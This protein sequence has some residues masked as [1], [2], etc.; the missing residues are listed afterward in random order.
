MKQPSINIQTQIQQGT[1]DPFESLLYSTFAQL[2]LKVKVWMRKFNW[3]NKHTHF[4]PISV[5]VDNFHIKVIIH[6]FTYKCVH[7]IFFGKNFF[8]SNKD[9]NFLRL[10]FYIL[11]SDSLYNVPVCILKF[12]NINSPRYLGNFYEYLQSKKRGFC[13]I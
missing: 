6:C 11:T 3:N 10:R 8:S 7:S 12:L 4:P 13:K 9:K 2:V 1:V 5:L